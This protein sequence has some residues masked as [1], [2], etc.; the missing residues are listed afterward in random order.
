MRPGLGF[1]LGILKS[2]WYTSAVKCYTSTVKC[3][4]VVLL[5]A[6]ALC[7]PHPASAAGCPRLCQPAIA[8]CRA[9]GFKRRICRRRLIGQC[10]AR[11]GGIC[12]FAPPTTTTTTTPVNQST[13]S[14]STTTGLT[15]TTLP[16]CSTPF[17]GQ[18][19]IQNG[20]GGILVSDTCG[21][22]D[23][24]LQTRFSITGCT[25]G[26]LLGS[27]QTPI[28]SLPSVP[29]YEEK[30]PPTA[31]SFNMGS[32]FFRSA[33]GCT[34]NVFVDAT[35]LIVGPG[36][37]QYEGPTTLTIDR[38]CDGVSCSTVYSGTGYQ[39]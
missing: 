39:S 27:I 2:L 15:T 36:T 20:N 29:A 17:V 33:D 1:T 21:L 35:D 32:T 7:S 22:D 13:T 10:H 14:T 18:W 37:S 11:G 19:L 16:Q 38:Q 8:E 12:V 30:R 24:R 25:D 34:Y 3:C 31:T 28:P 4:L 9:A 6:V 26:I 23:G 5:A